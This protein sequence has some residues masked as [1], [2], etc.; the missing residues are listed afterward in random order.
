MHHDCLCRNPG[1]AISHL[2]NQTKRRNLKAEP[3][4]TDSTTSNLAVNRQ[5]LSIARG[6]EELELS[7][8]AVLKTLRRRTVGIHPLGE[9]L[10]GDGI[11]VLA[12]VQALGK[13]GLGNG[14]GADVETPRN[15]GAVLVVVEGDIVR[16]SGDHAIL[17]G[18]PEVRHSRG[19]P[20]RAG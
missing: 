19:E 9:L 17:V 2:Y 7:S 14:A 8:A 12:V 20:I 5:S 16:E 1:D 18:L 10:L 6:C 13:G 3:K 15:E 4:E 11:R